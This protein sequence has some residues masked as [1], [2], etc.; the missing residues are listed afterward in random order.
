MNNEVAN[1]GG[2]AHGLFLLYAVLRG[3]HMDIVDMPVNSVVA[4]GGAMGVDFCNA[5]SGAR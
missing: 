5:L 3:H 4:N 1:I 2:N